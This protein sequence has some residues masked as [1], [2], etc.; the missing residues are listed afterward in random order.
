MRSELDTID[1]V[2]RGS[3]NTALLN[4]QLLGPSLGD[5]R[6]AP[7]LDRARAELR[8]VAEELLP[9]GLR[10]VGLEIKERVSLDLRRLVQQA[11][12][13]TGLKPV[14]LGP[15]PWPSV[16]G[17]HALLATAV[18]HLVRNA[19]AATPA[20]GPITRVT[21]EKRAGD[22]VTLA[23]HNRCRDGGPTLT[24]DGTPAIRGHL[25]GLVAVVRIARLHGGTLRFERAEGDLVALL[26]LPA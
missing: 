17:D 1:H 14:E 10:I 9:D 22:L 24:A 8:R 23:V 25:G 16:V 19:V 20:E 7:F 4:L 18:T 11:L 15:G 26:T 21:A 12:G 5:E 6:A 13:E 2:V 3:L